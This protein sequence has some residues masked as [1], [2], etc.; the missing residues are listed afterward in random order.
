[1]IALRP[2]SYDHP[3]A[4]E[5]TERAQAYYIDLYGGRD[6]DPLTAAEFAAPRGGFVVGYGG[7][8]HVAS[9]FVD[10]SM[11]TDDGRVRV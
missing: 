11:L 6:D 9:R 3:D 7:K 10:L 4:Q 1:M 8:S 2:V 5:L